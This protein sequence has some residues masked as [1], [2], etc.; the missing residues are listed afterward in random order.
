[1]SRFVLKLQKGDCRKDI[2]IDWSL[3][4][5]RGA[6]KWEGGGHVKF[7]PYE[8]GGGGGGKGFSHAEGGGHTM[9]WGSFYAV[10]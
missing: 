4:T 7:Y 1:M 10:A 2:S 5:G 9:F 6:T 3:I 8:N